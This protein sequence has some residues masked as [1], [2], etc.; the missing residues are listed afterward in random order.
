MKTKTGTIHLELKISAH[1]FETR[2][3]GF[4]AGPVSYPT[5]PDRALYRT[6]PNRD[7][8]RMTPER[9]LYPTTPYRVLYRTTPDRSLCRMTL[10][11]A[12]CRT[13]PEACPMPN[14]TRPFSTP[15]DTRPCLMPNDTDRALWRTW[16]AHAQPEISNNSKYNLKWSVLG[17]KRRL[18][19]CKKPPKLLAINF[20][21]WARQQLLIFFLRSHKPPVTH[22]L[23][24]IA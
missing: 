7:P 8:C 21:E 17:K 9:V 11:R 3:D 13:I 22:F 2:H 18:L 23:S 14:D 20:D 1:S 4:W 16:S 6:T 5:I 12:L 15:N 10:D 24:I 19:L